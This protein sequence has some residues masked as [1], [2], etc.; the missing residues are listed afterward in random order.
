ML[1]ARK[2]LLPGNELRGQKVYR[3]RVVAQFIKCV[4]RG[5][6]LCVCTVSAVWCSPVSN[7]VQ[8]PIDTV[9]KS[10]WHIQEYPA[11]AGHREPHQ[12]RTPACT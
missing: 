10:I 3:N 5:S 2:W 9:R 4:H 8:V 6:L 11:A 7:D 12:L 1:N